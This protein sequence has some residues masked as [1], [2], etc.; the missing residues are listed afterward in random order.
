[1]SGLTVERQERTDK[2]LPGLCGE[3]PYFSPLWW[4]CMNTS[5]KGVAYGYVTRED[6]NLGLTFVM[7]TYIIL[8]AH[9]EFFLGGPVAAGPLLFTHSVTPQ[10]LL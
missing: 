9:C 2:P 7:N 10:H 4:V 8:D 5:R 3:L 6:M 1:M